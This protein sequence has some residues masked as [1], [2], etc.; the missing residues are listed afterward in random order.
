METNPASRVN[1]FLSLNGLTKREIETALIVGSGKM[2]KEAA[3]ELKVGQQ[4]IKFHMTNVYRKLKIKR[5]AELK[6]I[7]DGVVYDKP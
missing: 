6:N 1:A 5:K 7:L 2:N 4:T 3:S